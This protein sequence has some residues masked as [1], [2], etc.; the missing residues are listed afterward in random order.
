MPKSP[1]TGKS[2]ATR[3][4]KPR[5]AAAVAPVPTHAEIATRAYELYLQRGGQDGQDFEDWLEAER[6]LQQ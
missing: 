3:T 2:R 6:E 1:K 4:A 5:A